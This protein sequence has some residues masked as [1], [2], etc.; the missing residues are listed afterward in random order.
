MHGVNHHLRVPCNMSRNPAGSGKSPVSTATRL[1]V[2]GLS[3]PGDSPIQPKSIFESFFPV[4]PKFACNLRPR[5]AQ[6][7]CDWDGTARQV[8]QPSRVRTLCLSRMPRAN[9]PINVA[10]AEGINSLWQRYTPP[11]SCRQ[12]DGI[13]VALPVLE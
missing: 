6:R 4:K 7:C 8:Q 11:P 2:S 13:S 12:P 1:P 10:T 5:V 9:A 3:N